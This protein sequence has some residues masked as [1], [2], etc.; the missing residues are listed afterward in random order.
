MKIAVVSDTHGYFDPHLS[1]LLRGV[2]EI[3][4]AGDVGSGQVLEQFR[5]IAQVHAVRGNVDT[6]ALALAPTLTREVG[7]VAIHMLHELP[8]PQSVLRDWAQLNPLEGKHAEHCRRFL[9]TFPEECR[10]V[11]FGHSHEPCALVVGG[12]FFFNPGSAGKRRFSL[13]RCFGILEVTEHDMRA[14][15]VSLDRYNEGIPEGV[16]LPI[17][18]ASAW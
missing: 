14:T 1:L 8:R 4:H 15:F 5:A 2:D 7:S 17:G 3:F 13:P 18:G 10:V 11:I 9:S 16:N 12:R 6:V